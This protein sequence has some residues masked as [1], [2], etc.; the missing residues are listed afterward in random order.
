MRIFCGRRYG[1]RLVSTCTIPGG[2]QETVL[3]DWGTL[4][5]YRTISPGASDMQ[6]HVSA[7]FAQAS[8]QIF[9]LLRHSP[10]PGSAGMRVHKNR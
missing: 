6:I 5:N 2:V 3:A 8:D 1:L 7:D 9:N 4:V 10:P